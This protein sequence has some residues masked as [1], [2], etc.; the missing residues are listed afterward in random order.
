MS[1][2]AFRKLLIRWPLRWMAGFDGN[3][4]PYNRV[5]FISVT[6]KGIATDMKLSFG[7]KRI[8][9]SA[10]DKVAAFGITSPNSIKPRQ[11]GVRMAVSG[12]HREL[13]RYETL[14][15]EAPFTHEISIGLLE[16]GKVEFTAQQIEEQIETLG[17]ALLEYGRERRALLPPQEPTETT[18]VTWDSYPHVV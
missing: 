5:P 4:L 8:P 15:L 6:T 16:N 9:W 14:G 10:I 1:D 17:A 3:W 18:A 13:R 2:D 7:V 12:N 11:I